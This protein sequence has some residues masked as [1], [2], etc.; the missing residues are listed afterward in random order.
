MPSQTRTFAESAVGE[1]EVG[2]IFVGMMGPGGSGR[3][4]E[5]LTP[6]A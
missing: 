4:A 3:C 2:V 5:V 1:V 6:A